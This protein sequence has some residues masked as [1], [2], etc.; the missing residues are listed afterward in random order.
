MIKLRENGPEHWAVRVLGLVLLAAIV[1]YIPTQSE[2]A[3]IGQLTDAFIL[4]VAALSLNL[5]F[6]FA[7]QISIGHSAFFGVGAY[8][9][10]ILVRDHG[11]SPGWTFYAGA[12]IA[13]VVGCVVA[14]PALRI[15]GIYLALVTL[16]VAV[17]FPTLVKWQKL[18][19]L[20]DGP[21]GI[22]SIRYDELPKWPFLG[23]LKGRDGRAVFGYWMA[24]V[25]VVVAYLVCRGIV[26]SRVGRSLVAIRDNETAAAVMGVN[27]AVTKA[28]VFGVSAAVCATAGSL[29]TLRTGVASPDG[30]YLTL[31]GS[32]LFLLVMVVGG[33]GTLTGPIVGGLAYVWLDTVTRDA[34]TGEGTGPISWVIEKLF[35]WT[36]QSPATIVLAI[37]LIVLMF[38]A[39]DGLVGLAKRLSR[40]VVQVVPRPVGGNSGTID[41]AGA[42][43]T[44]AVATGIA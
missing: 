4:I 5:V 20:T 40:R 11:W 14:L 1:I 3:R 21:R 37:V 34:G 30:T 18:E 31:I 2:T 8:A 9:T 42:P 16:G 32:I 19:W 39:P 15:K 17:L 29:Q 44:D 41:G 25:V 36:D 7:G 6:G 38:V 12:A 22:D 28:L 35:S 27:L 33:A 13:F 10:A 23:D 26:R 43:P 24:F